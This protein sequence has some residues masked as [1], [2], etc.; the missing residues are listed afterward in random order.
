[1]FE[2]LKTGDHVNRMVGNDNRFM[3]MIV[4][5]VEDTIIICTAIPCQHWPIE[6]MWK[7]DRK[8]GAEEDEDLRWGVK[9]GLTGTYLKLIT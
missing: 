2:H 8:T 5:K 6:E 3:E 1:M 4:V 7:F 9:F